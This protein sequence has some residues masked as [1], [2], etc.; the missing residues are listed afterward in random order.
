MRQDH[1]YSQASLAHFACVAATLALIAAALPNQA[2]A[3]STRDPVRE[4]AIGN[5]IVLHYVEA[6]RGPPL[7]FIHGSLSDYSYWQHQLDGFAPRYHVITYSRRY[8]YPNI[9]PP[10][11]GYSAIQDAEDLAALITR[12]HLGK[13]YIIGHSY[14]ALTALFLAINHPDLVRALVL[15]EPP[16]IPLLRYLPDEQ[17]KTGK[18]MYADIQAKMVEPMKAA[19]AAGDRDR[20]VGI[21]IDYVFNSPTAW[22]RMSPSDKAATLRDAHEW[23][24]IM[25]NGTLFPEV[26]PAVIRAIRVPVLVMSG[27][28]S[29]PFLG[30]IDQEL[31]RLIPNSRSIV[32]PEAGHQMWYSDPL[33][34]RHDAEAFF[35]TSTHG[36]APRAGQRDAVSYDRNTVAS[37]SRDRSDD[38]T[39]PLQHG[40]AP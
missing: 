17:T 40:S 33:L 16:V 27:G 6:G 1:R 18:A 9:N 13:V 7:V 10:R 34:C 8:N 29:Y 24:V 32:Y 26:D 30:Y 21:F 3:A 28:K 36:A 25:A 39:V 11:P 15:A 22:S 2:A 23:D 20:G 14:G 5:G 37:P 38:S 31:T 12:L 4:I 35:L 19:F